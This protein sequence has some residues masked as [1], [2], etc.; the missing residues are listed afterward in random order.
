MYGM[1]AEETGKWEE[2]TVLALKNCNSAPATIQLIRNKPLNKAHTFVKFMHASF[3]SCANK[4]DLA[5]IK[6]AG[7][8]DF[9]ACTMV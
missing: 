8:T 6:L 3:P 4:L 2:R 7:L 5:H 1:R 9:K